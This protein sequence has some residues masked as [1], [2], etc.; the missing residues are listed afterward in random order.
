M[1]RIIRPSPVPT[2]S[3]DKETEDLLNSNTT[4]MEEFRFHSPKN[5]FS[6][7]GWHGSPK[8]TKD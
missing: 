5:G 2:G 7:L 8:V 1:T 6:R 4:I 3:W